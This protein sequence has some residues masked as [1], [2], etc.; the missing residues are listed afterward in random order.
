MK[1]CLGTAFI[2]GTTNNVVA[3]SGHDCGVVK[4]NV[5]IK[6]CLLLANEVYKMEPDGSGA[7]NPGPLPAVANSSS[8]ET[9]D[10]IS[11]PAF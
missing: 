3:E 4:K 8:S 11:V 7:L 10:F 5:F 6:S 1:F 2:F 9:W